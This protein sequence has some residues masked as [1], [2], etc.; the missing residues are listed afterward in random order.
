MGNHRCDG[1][2]QRWF[3]IAATVSHRCDA[4]FSI[5]SQRHSL[6]RKSVAANVNVATTRSRRGEHSFLQRPK[7]LRRKTSQRPKSLQESLR[8]D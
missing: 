4:M 2:S 8:S 5:A 6:R 7:S 1:Q 3:P